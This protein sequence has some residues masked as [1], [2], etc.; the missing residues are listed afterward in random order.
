MSAP[1]QSF[2]ARLSA[3]V[4]KIITATLADGFDEVDAIERVLAAYPTLTLSEY[5]GAVVLHRA[6]SGARGYVL[7]II[8][9]GRA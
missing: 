9:Q 8:E 1:R 3:H 6:Q 7:R 5:L 4:A 2:R